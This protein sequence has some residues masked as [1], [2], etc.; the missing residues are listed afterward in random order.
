MVTCVRWLPAR[1]SRID[2]SRASIGS[3]ARHAPGW[4][5][6]DLLRFLSVVEVFLEEVIEEGAHHGDGA[7][8]ADVLPRRRDDAAD[9]VGRQLELQTDQQ[10]HAKPAPD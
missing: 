10:P 5:G 1:A 2:S 6:L 9:D 4:Q 8:L 7:Q 3:S